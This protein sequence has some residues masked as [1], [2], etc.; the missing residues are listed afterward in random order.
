MPSFTACSALLSSSLSPSRRE[1]KAGRAQQSIF[2]S[3]MQGF[4]CVL[5][6]EVAALSGEA[7][8]VQHVPRGH[9]SGVASNDMAKISLSASP[10]SLFHDTI[11]SHKLLL[12]FHFQ[13]NRHTQS[14]PP[15]LSQAS[16]LPTSRVLAPTR[17]VICLYSDHL[18]SSCL[19]EGT[20]ALLEAPAD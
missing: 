9:G 12:K 6:T 3:F 2:G 13:Q 15:C 1:S 18:Q 10:Q 11:S 17:E 8:V 4:C 20:G 19:M 14:S 16:H 5:T 7:V